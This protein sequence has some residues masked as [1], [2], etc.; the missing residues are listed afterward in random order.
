ML[1]TSG[2]V[3]GTLS[4]EAGPEHLSGVV[5]GDARKPLAAFGGHSALG[6]VPKG[7]GAHDQGEVV[8][9]RKDFDAFGSRG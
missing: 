4:N 2:D 6:A 1:Q 3:L 8:E 9:V 7:A 5:A